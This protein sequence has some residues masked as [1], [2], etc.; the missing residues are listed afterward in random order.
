MTYTQ[1]PQ[2][3]EIAF[4]VTVIPMMKGSS[5]VGNLITKVYILMERIRHLKAWQ[6]IT[7]LAMIGLLV[8]FLIGLIQAG[9]W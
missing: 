1:I 6:Q 7:L 5:V 9:S 8:G 2:R 4:W 3:I